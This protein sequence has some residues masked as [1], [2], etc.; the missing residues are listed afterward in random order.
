ME[1]RKIVHVIYSG[2][3]GHGNVLFPLL[4]GKFGEDF[5][6]IVV[7]YGVEPLLPAYIQRCEELGLTYHQI[8]K[9]RGQYLKP[10][11]LFIAVLKKVQPSAIIVHNSE[12][13][14][15]AVG[16]SKHVKSC[17][18]YYVE[19]QDNKTKS[20]ILRG[21]SRYALKRADAVV[22]LSENFK[23]ELLSKCTAS[24]PVKV[25]ANGINTEKYIPVIHH[26]EAIRIGMA[27]R[28][29]PTKDHKT[30]L[31]A[32]RI[33]LESY[34]TTI[35]EIAGSGDTLLQTQVMC[36]ELELDES[37]RFL[38]LLDE[39][40]M[41]AFYQNID[42]F[43]LATTSETMSTAILQAM[44]C[45]LPVVTS[46]IENNAVLIEHGRTGWLYNDQ[47]AVDL[48]VK[49][50]VILDDREKALEVG[51]AA[52]QHVIDN[53]SLEKMGQSYISLIE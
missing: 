21:L 5:T 15:T 12:L 47:N 13:I 2:L 52:R 27:A 28:M 46:D 16:Y 29:T 37:V 49:L 11:R 10:F 7:F 19:H 48:A 33:L 24:V 43:V 30:L 45:G 39:K 41:I 36:T 32:F 44:S 1:K 18:A 8:Q 35:L 50:N 40:E 25:V 20:F 42:I 3:G 23:Q 31:N 38:G 4:E 51:R 17:K 6:N 14:I 9:R 53:Y 26:N 22:C 34:P